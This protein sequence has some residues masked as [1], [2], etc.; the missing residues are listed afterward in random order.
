MTDPVKLLVASAALLVVYINYNSVID[1]R[2]RRCYRI[3]HISLFQFVGFLFFIYWKC[4]CH[5]Q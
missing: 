1:I 5:D 3:T 2:C 4:P